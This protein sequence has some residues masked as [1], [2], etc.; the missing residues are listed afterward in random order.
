MWG[1]GVTCVSKAGIKGTRMWEHQPEARWGATVVQ[2]HKK[3]EPGS[4]L[5]F[6]VKCVM[7]KCIVGFFF[8]QG[9]YSRSFPPSSYKYWFWGEGADQ[10]LREGMGR[11]AGAG[12]VAWNHCFLQTSCTMKPSSATAPFQQCSFGACVFVLVSRVWCVGVNLLPLCPATDV[13]HK[14]PGLWRCSSVIR[15]EFFAEWSFWWGAFWWLCLKYTYWEKVHRSR[16]SATKSV[17]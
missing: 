16:T 2:P 10:G 13:D 7:N 4:D 8:S 1:T 11:K 9:C 6:K 17:Q 15:E 12:R 3:G 5:P 14:A